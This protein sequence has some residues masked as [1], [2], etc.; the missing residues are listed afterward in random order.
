MKTTI[1]H[2]IAAVC[3][4]LCMLPAFA[5]AFNGDESPVTR[6][7][8]TMELDL[9]ADGFPNDGAAHYDQWQ[10]FLDKLSLRGTV[11]TQNA[12]MPLNRVYFDGGLYLNDKLTVPF[13]YDSYITFRYLRS[14]ALGG[15]SVHFQMNNFLQ[16]MLKGYYYMGLPTQYIA[17]PIYPQAFVQLYQ[18][19]EEPL[20]KYLAGEGSR[21]IDY[22]TLY[23][24]CQE[25]NLIVQEDLNYRTYYLFT[26]LLFDLG[27]SDM[28]LE[29][30]AY[31]EDWLD[32]LDPDSEGMTITV[33]DGTETWVLGETTVFEKNDE[34]FTVYLPDYD[35][36]EYRF[37][38]Q[39]VDGVLSAQAQV[40]QEEEEYLGVVMELSG[41][42]E[43][44]ETEAEGRL[45]VSFS[46]SG[47]YYHLTDASFAFRYARTAEKLP[48]QTSLEIDWLHP[49]TG[50][51]AMGFK[52]QA[53]CE[54]QPYTVLKERPYDNQDDFFNLNESFMAEYKE[55]FLPT[56]ALAAAPIMLEMPAGVM[57]DVIAFMDATGF[58]SFLGFE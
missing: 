2:R 15:A 6:S 41:L 33:E 56:A 22:N 26:C 25:L 9:Y 19:Y 11:D 40:L 44:G 34:G 35:G 42:P 46:G 52:Y 7:D 39:D 28:L 20:T 32:W 53:D 18:Q 27:L 45:D 12:W 13:E 8:F 55:R 49:E 54:E 37:T 4:C 38:C 24:L 1:L 10:A 30:L 51:P 23:E 14:P 57:S 36:Y 3:L 21:M 48:Y 47:Y 43:E 16:F 58:L 50:L 31:T 29:K 5:L 17:L